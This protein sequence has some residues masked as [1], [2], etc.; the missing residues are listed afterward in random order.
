MSEQMN[1]YQK[2]AKIRKPV[3]IIQKKIR[4]R[5]S[6]CHGRSDSCQDYRTYGQTWRVS[7]SKFRRWKHDGFSVFL[8]ED[9]G[10]EERR[11]VSGAGQRNPCE[12]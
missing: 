7:C 6:L 3:E 5:I 11:R 8:R 12:G 4:L 10:R 1:I 9:Q 2:L